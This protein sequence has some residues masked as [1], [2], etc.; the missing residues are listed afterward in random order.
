MI[1]HMVTE[2]N[3]LLHAPSRVLTRAEIS[4]KKIQTFIQDMIATMYAKDGVGL[5]AVQVGQPLQLCVILKSYNTLNPRQDLCLINPIWTK[6]SRHQEWGQE[7]CLSVP[8]IYG[9]IKR[10]AKIKVSAL[11][12]Q[13]QLLEFIA[14]DFFARIVQHE[15]DH[16]NGHLYVEK[17]KDFFSVTKE[18]SKKERTS[19]L[20]KP[21]PDA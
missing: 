7:G 2:P 4:T 8:G 3:P 14:E 12:E 1:Y 16:L 21:A 10:Y 15:V 5:A 6:L 17:A 9:H 13:G 20:L 11:N 19:R 18:K